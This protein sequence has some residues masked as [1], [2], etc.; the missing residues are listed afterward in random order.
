MVSCA[1]ADTTVELLNVNSLPSPFGGDATVFSDPV[2]VNENRS[3]L[4]SGLNVRLSAAPLNFLS[5]P[6]PM[7][8]L[9]RVSYT[10]H[11]LPKKTI[12]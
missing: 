6:D 7:K 4:S 2:P 9:V 8:T 12:V 10:N 1:T 3:C 5:E 11:T